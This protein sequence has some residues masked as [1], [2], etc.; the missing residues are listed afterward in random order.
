M[1]LTA[2]AIFKYLATQQSSNTQSTLD[3]AQSQL[4]KAWSKVK[5]D[6]NKSPMTETANALGVVPA[7]SPGQTVGQ[8]LL[9]DLGRG[10][11]LIELLKYW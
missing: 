7:P 3:R 1:A 4:A 6:A 5:D 8:K 9:P 11:S 10:P 2:S